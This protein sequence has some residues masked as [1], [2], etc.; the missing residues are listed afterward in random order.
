MDKYS[1]KLM[2]RIENSILSLEKMPY[3]CPERKRGTYDS[4]GCI[5]MKNL[6]EDRL[7][8]GK[9]YYLKMM[10]LNWRFR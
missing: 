5:D 2:N 7:W 1:V 10:E 8:K 9:L 3:R 6:T 4:R